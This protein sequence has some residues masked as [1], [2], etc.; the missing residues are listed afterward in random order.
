MFKGL[1]GEC[2]YFNH[3]E[4][5]VVLKNK[6]KIGKRNAII[7]NYFFQSVSIVFKRNIFLQD[8]PY[9]NRI[10]RH[11]DLDQFKQGKKINKLYYFDAL[12]K[13]VKILKKL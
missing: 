10:N 3:W 12:I 9:A 8:D 1:P 2:F 13:C 6:K 4:I 5:E 7:E 11:I